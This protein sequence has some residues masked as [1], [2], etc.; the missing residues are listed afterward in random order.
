MITDVKVLWWI[1][2]KYQGSNNC[3]A[4][5]SKSLKSS[6]TSRVRRA[7]LAK[8]ARR[9]PQSWPNPRPPKRRSAYQN[10]SNKPRTPLSTK[11]PKSNRPQ[12]HTLPPRATSQTPGPPS[13]SHSPPCSSSALNPKPPVLA[14]TNLILVRP[15]TNNSTRENDWNTT[16]S[17]NATRWRSSSHL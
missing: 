13:A 11:K 1:W 12:L 3:K 8:T 15:T 16:T 17:A 4:F 7:S 14:P 9:R 5:K 10:Q 2:D 6:Q